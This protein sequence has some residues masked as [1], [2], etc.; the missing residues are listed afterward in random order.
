MTIARGTASAY[1]SLDEDSRY[2]VAGRLGLGSIIGAD[3][4]EIPANR[5]FYAGG[6]GSYEGSVIEP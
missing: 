5:R 4:E 3:L 1:H 6:G 2:V